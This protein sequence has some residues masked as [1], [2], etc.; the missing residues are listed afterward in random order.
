MWSALLA[1]LCMIATAEEADWIEESN[2]HALHVMETMAGFNPED[3]GQMGIEGMDEMI[4]DLSPGYD[5]R[6]RTTLIQLKAD[7]EKAL[8]ET[9]HKKVRQDLQ[10]LISAVEDQ[11]RGDQLSDRYFFDY[12]N[13]PQT[14][15]FGI[16][17]LLHPQ[18]DPARYPA[19]V[20]RLKKYAGLD[21]GTPITELAKAHMLESMKDPKLLGPSLGQLENHLSSAPQLLAGLD[22]L[23]NK[24]ELEGY[25][26]ALAAVKTQVAD[27]TAFLEKE[28]KPRARKDFRLP[29]EMYAYN[30][31]QYGVR[32]Q[33][34]ELMEQARLAYMEI[35]NEMRALAP[36]IAEKHGWKETDYKSVIKKLKEKQFKGEEILPKYQ[37]TMAALEDL[38]R[39]H[40]IVSLPEKDAIIR[41]ASPAESAV[42]PA[43]HLQPPPLIGNSG[44]RPEF[45][46]P[47]AVN[48]EPGKEKMDDFTFEAAA[49]TLSV[50]EGRPGHELQF[51]ALIEKG[52]SITRSVFAFNS[53]N[54][55]GWALYSEAVMKPYMPLEGQIISLQHRLLRAA[56]AY[57]D[58]MLQLGLINYDDAKAFLKENVVL[59]E[60]MAKQE[61]DRYTFRAPGQATSYFYGY[62]QWMKLREEAERKMGSD[63]NLK[64]FHDFCLAQGLLPPDL[65][66]QAVNEEFIK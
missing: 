59:S 28:V 42:Q 55:E 24:F 56:R 31:V 14:I 45:V 26:E 39:K 49:W 27:Y 1:G 62:M 12:Y 34:R 19:A 3:A 4:L 65:L 52:V 35:I 44:E 43:P 64:G 36:L 5:E 60:A 2:K 57:L 9:E 8:A 66:K 7:L 18:V 10:I 41:L 48:A 13:I 33:P 54:V 6:Q 50:H 21:G 29:E 40:E 47:S 23:F 58:P 11:L 15:F 25:E 38:I 17:Y 30:L 37:Q 32:A 46:L 16:Q 61:A 51:T 22:E 53:V 63:F 20:V